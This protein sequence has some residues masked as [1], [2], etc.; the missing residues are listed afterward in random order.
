MLALG[1]LMRR[2]EFALKVCSCIETFLK[3]EYRKHS[4]LDK[5]YGGAYYWNERDI[6]WAFYR[7]LRDRTN[8]Y[9]IG[10]EWWVHAEGTIERPRYVR[11]KK[12]KGMKRADVVFINHSDFKRWWRGDTDEY[13]PYKAMIEIKLIWSGSGKANTIQGIEKDIRKLE[14]CLNDG[15]TENAFFVLLDGLDRGRYPYYQRDELRNLK[16]N[17]YLII[18]HWPDC[19]NPI[20]DPASAVFKK[21]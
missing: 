16:T 12:W 1:G 8:P 17:P 14:V 15:T 9:S 6:Q 19:K 7:H 13:P 21:Y 11:K 4:H 5:N 10:S 2:S 18:Y 3:D 20:D